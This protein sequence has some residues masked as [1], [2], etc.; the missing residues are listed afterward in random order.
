MWTAKTKQMSSL[1]TCHIDIFWHSGWK[2][3][4]WK[5]GPRKTCQ[6]TWSWTICSSS[7]SSMACSHTSDKHWEPWFDCADVLADKGLYTSCMY[8][9]TFLPSYTG[10]LLR[11]I[12]FLQF[13]IKTCC[14]YSL[15]VPH[16]GTSNEYPQ[17]MSSWRNKKKNVMKYSSL[18]RPLVHSW[19]WWFLYY[20]KYR[21]TELEEIFET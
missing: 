16:R 4:I 18:T 17:H 20:Q 19:H 7:V 6:F 14:E 9:G 10:D 21:S 2:K 12:V 3:R 8:Y 5:W 11:W 13:S 1:E 15:A